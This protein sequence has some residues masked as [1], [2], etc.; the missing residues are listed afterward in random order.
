MA[1]ITEHRPGVYGPH[2]GTGHCPLFGKVTV[3]FGYDYS[4]SDSDSDSDS[5]YVPAGAMIL[6]FQWMSFGFRYAL[7]PHPLGY[8][9][10]YI[11]VGS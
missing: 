8:P 9:R 6:S 11:A 3:T 1:H 10:R 2:T 4:S 5:E 7:M